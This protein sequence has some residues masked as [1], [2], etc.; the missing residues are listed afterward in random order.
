MQL[1]ALDD[2][3]PVHAAGAEKGKNYL[4]PE[5]RAPVRIRGGPSRQ[6]HFYHL[7]AQ[8]QCRQHQKSLEHLQMQLRLLTLIGTNNADV[9]CP[10]P[11][12]KRIADVA[13]HPRKIV[14]EIQCSPI[15][16]EEAK[17]RTQ[18]YRNAD[19]EVIWILH[20][21]QF[22]GRNLSASEIFLRTTSCYFTDIDKTGSGIIY[23][24]FE[25]LKKSRRLFKGPKLPV[26]P[27]G[28]VPIASISAPE[29]KCWPSAASLRLLSWKYHTRGD[30]VD[31][32]LKEGNFVQ[33]AEN[34]LSIEAR[35]KKDSPKL[36]KLPLKKLIAK[37]YQAALDWALKKIS[38]SS[39]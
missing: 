25:V 39:A 15:P 12:I 13:W 21:R 9:E 6:L 22:N 32:L 8:R 34:M 37:C 11:A 5:C 7:S 29:W 35:L 27:T 20:D 16:L 10:F 26:V 24:Q 4:C 28:I 14:F 30:L 2:A 33:T 3:T 17:G 1:Y 38:S 23:D 31:R 18:D 19:Y 36:E